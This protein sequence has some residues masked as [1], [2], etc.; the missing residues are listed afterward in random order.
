MD[1]RDITTETIHKGREY[2]LDIAYRLISEGYGPTFSIF[3]GEPGAGPEWDVHAVRV[4]LIDGDDGPGPWHWIEPKKGKLRL[5]RAIANS[6]AVD[7]AILHDIE[8]RSELSPR[9]RRR[10]A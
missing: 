5:F 9:R 1:E 2:E 6:Q 7:E 8:A 10:F 3:G 4:R